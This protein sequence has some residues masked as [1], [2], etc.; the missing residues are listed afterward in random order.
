MQEGCNSIFSLLEYVC[1]HYFNQLLVLHT[2]VVMNQQCQV[3]VKSN[4]DVRV[5]VFVVYI[6]EQECQA[7]EANNSRSNYFRVQC[8]QNAL[9]I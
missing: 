6:D 3:S 1:N 2:Q 7:N 8:R 5:R 4:C 9:L